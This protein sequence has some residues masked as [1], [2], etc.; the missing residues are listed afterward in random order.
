MFIVQKFF[1]D[2]KDI[3]R[4]HPNISFLHI[5]FFDYQANKIP[6]HYN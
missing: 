1:N 6:K 3:F 2:G 4:L 5:T